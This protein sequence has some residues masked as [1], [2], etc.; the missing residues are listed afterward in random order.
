MYIKYSTRPAKKE[1]RERNKKE[2]KRRKNKEK[3]KEHKKNTP[4]K[5]KVL[6]RKL[7][8]KTKKNKHK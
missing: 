8:N 3:P 7:A 2:E 1:P 6:D 5:I 4:R